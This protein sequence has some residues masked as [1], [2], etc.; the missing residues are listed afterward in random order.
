MNYNRFT[1]RQEVKDEIVAGKESMM[2]RIPIRIRKSG[3]FTILET[4]FRGC[5]TAIWDLPEECIDE[6]ENGALWAH[7]DAYKMLEQVDNNG[8]IVLRYRKDI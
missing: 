7:Y 1:K 8:Y 4:A 6:D 5:R 3:K 2:V